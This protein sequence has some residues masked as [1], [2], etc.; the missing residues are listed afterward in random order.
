[1]TTFGKFHIII[2]M[3]ITKYFVEIFYLRFGVDTL[4]I[5]KLITIRI[6][7]GI[8]IWII[9][10][11][12]I[13]ACRGIWRLIAAIKALIEV[14][15]LVLALRIVAITQGNLLFHLRLGFAYLWQLQF[16]KFVGTAGTGGSH[17]GAFALA[18]ACG[19]SCLFAFIRVISRLSHPR[20][21]RRYIFLGHRRVTLDFTAW[22]LRLHARSAHNFR[23]MWRLV[24]L[25]LATRIEAG[26]IHDTRSGVR[27]D[28]S[29]AR[30]CALYAVTSR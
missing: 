29:S 18:S 2:L 19:I 12:L 26:V 8:S 6:E 9:P 14:S 20:L 13:F 17:V 4:P 23:T 10:H 15:N 16:E 27:H 1:M 30:F 28:V 7:V 5:S 24:C 25:F 22:I 21:A 11:P 3:M